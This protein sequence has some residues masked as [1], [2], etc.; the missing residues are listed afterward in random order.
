MARPGSRRG[1]LDGLAGAAAMPTG[2]RGTAAAPRPVGATRIS[3]GHCASEVCDPQPRRCVECLA[4]ADCTL[5]ETCTG[6]GE[7]NVCGCTLLT[8]EQICGGEPFGAGSGDDTCGG[9]DTCACP[10]TTPT[11]IFVANTTDGSTN[12]AGFTIP[13]DESGSRCGRSASMDRPASI[14]ARPAPW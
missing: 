4:D 9:T 5:P 7:A 10:F 1:F 2:A 3:N 13:T 8:F 6:G 11:V 12:G 14:T